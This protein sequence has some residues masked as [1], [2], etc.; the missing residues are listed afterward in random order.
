MVTIIL[1]ILCSL[2]HQAEQ[3][4]PTSLWTRLLEHRTHS[5]V[6]VDFAEMSSK[7]TRAG[8]QHEKGGEK[9]N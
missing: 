9:K 3:P 1:H 2:D 6:T 4:A 8:Q 5:L 7:A